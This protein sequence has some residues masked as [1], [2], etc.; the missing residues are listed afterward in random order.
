MT[1]NSFFAIKFKKMDEIDGEKFK[2]FCLSS[3][4]NEIKKALEYLI[5]PNHDLD[6]SEKSFKILKSY[7][8]GGICYDKFRSES[9]NCNLNKYKSG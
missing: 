6:E 9:K 1:Y 7:I 4:E 2:K 8:T 5:D 3:N